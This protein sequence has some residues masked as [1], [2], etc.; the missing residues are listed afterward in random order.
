MKQLAQR[1]I[2]VTEKFPQ[3]KSANRARVYITLLTYCVLLGYETN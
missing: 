1:K 2:T 3:F